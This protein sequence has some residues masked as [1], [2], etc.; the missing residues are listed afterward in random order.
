MPKVDSWGNK[1][2]PP[3]AVNVRTAPNRQPA[4]TGLRG[5]FQI[6]PAATTSAAFRT[7][8]TMHDHRREYHV[9]MILGTDDRS[10]ANV[11]T[12]DAIRDELTSWAESL[13]ATAHTVIVRPVEPKEER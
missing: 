6:L 2:G 1:T 3:D 5:C 7:E 11:Q 4:V 8:G 10:H 13:D 9:E 12:P